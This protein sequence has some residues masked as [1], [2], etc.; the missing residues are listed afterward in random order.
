MLGTALWIAA[1][2]GFSVAACS[3]SSMRYGHSAMKLHDCQVSALYYFIT[4]GVTLSSR[5]VVVAGL[6]RP[7]LPRPYTRDTDRRRCRFLFRELHHK[8]VPGLFWARRKQGPFLMKKI[9]L[10]QYD[11]STWE[12]PSFDE[13]QYGEKDHEYALV[14]PVINEGNRIQRQP[15]RILGAELPVDVIVADGGSNDGS[16]D[17]D[18]MR[19]VNVTTV[20]IKTGPGKLSAQLRMAYAWCIRQVIK[21]S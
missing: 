21:G 8:Q 11:D 17:P 15:Q 5:L 20:L 1:A 2:V 4:S 9:H 6:E 18:Y 16:L 3:A 13:V 12:L 7:D 19:E 10:S 14:I